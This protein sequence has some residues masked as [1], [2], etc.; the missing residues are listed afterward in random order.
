MTPTHKGEERF[1]S[2]WTDD[3]TLW[4]L[5]HSKQPEFASLRQK[6]NET[7][8][9][10]EQCD[11]EGEVEV[12]IPTRWKVLR[13]SRH[14]KDYGDHPPLQADWQTVLK[15]RFEECKQRLIVGHREW[16]LTRHLEGP[17]SVLLVLK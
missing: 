4:H 9:D 13:V 11:S 6:D 17:C 1:T 10:A 5:D 8:N 2:I 15:E 14:I 7:G 3:C 16:I 12:G